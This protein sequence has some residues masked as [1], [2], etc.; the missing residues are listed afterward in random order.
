M[1]TE[2]CAYY[3]LGIECDEVKDCNGL[4][5]TC[6]GYLTLQHIKDFHKKYGL[7]GSLDNDLL[8]RIEEVEKE[9]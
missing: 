9:N 6:Y 3:R 2:E 8:K 7:T 5:Q 4:S 1:R